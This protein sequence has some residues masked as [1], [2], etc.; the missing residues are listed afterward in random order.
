MALYKRPNSKYYWFKFHF[1]G[2]LVQRSSQCANK[3]DALTVESAFRMQ[4]ALG[5]IGIAPK[6]EIPTFEKAVKD[7]LCWLKVEHKDSSTYDRYHF[8]CEPL[9]KFFGKQKVDAIETKTIEKFIVSRSS[10][11]SRKTGKAIDNATTNRELLTLKKI[12][13]RLVEARVLTHNPVEAVKRLPEAD[14]PFYVLNP[15]EEKLYLFACSPLLADVAVLMMETGARP[16]EVAELRRQDI[17]LSQDYFQ[18]RKGKTKAARRKVFLTSK[19]KAVLSYR[20]KKFKSDCVFPFN[21]VDG[22]TTTTTDALDKLHLKAIADLS[23]KFRLYDCRHTAATRF[24]EKGK[25]DLVTLAAILGHNSLRM[26]MR[27]AHP[28]ENHKADAIRRMEKV[29]RA[30]AV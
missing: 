14:P 1:D 6:K 27:Y 2:E 23:F 19:A 10:Q 9:K 7:F 5:K 17:F 12:F 21:D 25:V 3:R 24:L 16:S 26:V 13:R 20:L 30:K 11:I 22:M 8:A 4:L 29:K 18:I 15:K 28:S